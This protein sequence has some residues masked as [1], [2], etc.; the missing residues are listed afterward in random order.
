MPHV[1][2]KVLDAVL[3]DAVD[4]VLRPWKAPPSPLLAVAAALERG[5][6]APPLAQAPFAEKAVEERVFPPLARALAAAANAY[7][8]QTAVSDARHFFAEHL[9]AAASPD[10]FTLDG[11]TLTGVSLR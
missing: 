5:D 7:Y 1:E 2:E 4:A 3:S 9:R 10:G 11:F 8:A 6:Q